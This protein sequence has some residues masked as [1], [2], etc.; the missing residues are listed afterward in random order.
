MGAQ[1]S[2]IYVYAS[3]SEVLAATIVLLLL[4]IL[5]VGP[6][7]IARSRQ[8]ASFG[9]DDYTIFLALVSFALRLILKVGPSD[10]SEQ[11]C[12]IGMAACTLYGKK[13]SVAVTVCQS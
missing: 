7:F 6:K 4:G 3:P 10:S 12:V 9:K 5:S 1:S 13:P 8:R 2:L 11:L